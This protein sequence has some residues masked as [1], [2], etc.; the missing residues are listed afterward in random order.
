[1]TASLFVRAQRARMEGIM[2]VREA[3]QSRRVTVFVW[4]DG[5][6]QFLGEMTE[7]GAREHKVTAT[8]P[9]EYVGF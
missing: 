5:Q 6:W 2:D 1:M 9:C 7:D 3:M 8:M 4:Y